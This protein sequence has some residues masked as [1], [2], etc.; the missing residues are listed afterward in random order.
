MLYMSRYAAMPLYATLMLMPC[1]RYAAATLRYGRDA[2][3]YICRV[4]APRVI[5]AVSFITPFRHFFSRA[6]SMIFADD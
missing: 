4:S 1:L 6:F 3:A 5:D 2:D